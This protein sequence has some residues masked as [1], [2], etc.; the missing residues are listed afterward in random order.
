M[1]D[2][3]YYRT[4]NIEE[5]IGFQKEFFSVSGCTSGVTELMVLL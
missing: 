1:L 3:E 5:A 2:R 4:Q